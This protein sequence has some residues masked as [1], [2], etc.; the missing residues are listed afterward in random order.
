MEFAGAPTIKP[1]YTDGLKIEF[2]R[3]VR[4]ATTK[5]TPSKTFYTNDFL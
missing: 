1:C 3:F 5:N 4:G 2:P